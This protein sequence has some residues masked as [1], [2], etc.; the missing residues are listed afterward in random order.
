VQREVVE[1]KIRDAG[2]SSFRVWRPWTKSGPGGK[3][4]L[5][6]FNLHEE[7]NEWLLFHG[8]SPDAL[9]NIAKHGF[10]MSKVGLGAT[11]DWEGALPL[12]GYGGYF[13]DSPTKADEYSRIKLEEGPYKGCRAMAL[14]R[15]LGGRYLYCKKDELDKKSLHGMILN[16]DCDSTIG[17]RLRLRGTFREYVVYDASSIYLEYILYYK[18]RYRQRD[19]ARVDPEDRD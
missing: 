17:D 3:S 13:T 18:R 9:V 10:S 5:D 12:Y 4:D 15:V 19:L 1:Q 8:T 11:K 16:G 7:A 6:L 14:F 2:Q